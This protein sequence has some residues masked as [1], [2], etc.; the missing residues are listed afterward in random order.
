MAIINKRK[1]ETSPSLRS[2]VV[3]SPQSVLDRWNAAKDRLNQADT[4]L[5]SL[6]GLQ[7]LD[8]QQ[9]LQ[10]LRNKA[11]TAM[12]DWKSKIE[13]AEQNHAQANATVATLKTELE[14]LNGEYDDLRR[15]TQSVQQETEEL[16][17]ER[18]AFR[19]FV[20]DNAQKIQETRQQRKYTLPRMQQ[21][22]SLYATMTGIKWDFDAQ[23]ENRN[24]LAGEVRVP[25]Q[26]TMRHFY[27]HKLD[28]SEYELANLLWDMMDGKLLD[29]GE[30]LL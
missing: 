21:Q 14:R 7:S 16:D 6:Q 10:T 26:S 9:P 28:Y 23:I 8:R 18:E 30:E 20:L 4:F 27:I 25:S 19:T 3:V 13:T 12:K 5:E 24:V 17:A 2:T 22:F 11:Q 15:Q 29:A 1:L